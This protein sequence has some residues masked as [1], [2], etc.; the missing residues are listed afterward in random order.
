MSTFEHLTEPNKL[1]LGLKTSFECGRIEQTSSSA[2]GAGK[3]A[4]ETLSAF[5]VG[6]AL[7]ITLQNINL[8]LEGFPSFSFSS[9]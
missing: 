7:K 3:G 8:I 5:S 4:R 6:T 9:K 1:L 2:P